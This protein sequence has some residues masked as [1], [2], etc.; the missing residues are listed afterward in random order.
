MPTTINDLPVEILYQILTEVKY[1]ESNTYDD[2]STWYWWN[3]PPTLNSAGR[4][5]RL[6]NA[7]V[8]QRFGEDLALYKEYALE[9]RDLESRKGRPATS[10]QAQVQ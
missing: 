6:W 5:C 7:M 3:Y 4:V 1:L 9:L 2:P 8:A 10:A